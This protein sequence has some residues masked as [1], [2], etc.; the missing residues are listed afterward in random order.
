LGI[1]LEIPENFQPISEELFSELELI[2]IEIEPF[3]RTIQHA[4][5]ESSGKGILIISEL[6]FI[7]G[8]SPER[9]PLDY[10]NIYKRNLAAHYGVEEIIGEE[11]HS[12]DITT[13]VLAMIF[14]DND[15]SLFKGLSYVFPNRF[16]MIDLYVFNTNVTRDDAIGFQN[17]FNSLKT[18]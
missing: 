13:V 9:H 8:V 16:F 6:E 5:V 15:Y 4:F 1:A 2:V 17:V 14:G 11:I 12:N 7:E 10:I 18:F 3:T